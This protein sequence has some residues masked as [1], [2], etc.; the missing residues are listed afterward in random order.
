MKVHPAQQNSAG[1]ELAKAGVPSASNFK[2]IIK[3]KSGLYVRSDQWRGYLNQLAGERAFKIFGETFQSEEM[4]RGLEL[5]EEARAD[6]SFINAVEMKEVGF[7]TSDDG[8]YGCS[9]DS[10]I[11]DD[12]GYEGK[13]PKFHNHVK[14]LLAQKIPAEYIGQVQG[15]LYV[16]QREHWWFHSFYN[17]PKV[18]SFQTK[19]EPDTKY[20]AALE[21]FLP[22]FIGELEETTKKLL[23]LA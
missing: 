17:D 6:F 5:E 14:I 4:A 20:Q 10:L 16:T 12:S 2:K 15:C 8:S 19:I 22:E 18:P 13:A 9:P 11:G 23:E 1:W 7:C 21:K 3:L